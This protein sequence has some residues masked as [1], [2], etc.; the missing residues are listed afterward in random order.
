M[1]TSRILLITIFLFY[2][3][4]AGHKKRMPMEVKKESISSTPCMLLINLNLTETVPVLQ[5]NVLRKERQTLCV[6]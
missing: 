6:S 5:L 3:K 2:F 1:L 4:K